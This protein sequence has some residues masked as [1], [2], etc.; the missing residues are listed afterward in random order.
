MG[1]I[2]LA[3]RSRPA[4]GGRSPLELGGR[5]WYPVMDGVIAATHGALAAASFEQAG[6]D[7]CTH[8]IV[9]EVDMLRVYNEAIAVAHD[10][11]ENRGAV[12]AMVV[13]EGLPVRIEWG[14][15]AQS[16]VHVHGRHFA[17]HRSSLAGREPIRV[18][19]ARRVALGQHHAQ[20]PGD[21]DLAAAEIA[22]EHA[23]DQR[24]A[25]LRREHVDPGARHHVGDRAA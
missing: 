1:P 7:V 19:A 22:L 23:A 8:T 20:G 18:E 9:A 21:D 5:A 17:D 25:G 14:H 11:G 24:D 6:F 10:A 16:R 3:A 12:D 2:L 15:D 4:T 13:E